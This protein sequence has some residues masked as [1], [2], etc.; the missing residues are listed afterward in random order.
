M[1]YFLSD[2]HLGLDLPHDSSTEREKRIVAFLTECLDDA[3]ELYLLGDIF[4]YW[5]EFRNGEHPN[6]PTFFSVLKK[7]Q[8]KHIPVYQFCGNHDLWLGSFLTDNFDVQIIKQP[9]EKTILGKR[10]YLAHGDG[11]GKGDI[12]YKLLKKLFTSK[13][14]MSLYSILPSRL[15]FSIMKFFSDLSRKTHGHDSFDGRSDRLLA[16]CNEYSTQHDIDYYLMGHRHVLLRLP[17]HD[18]EYIN[19][20]DWLTYDSYASFDGTTLKLVSNTNKT[21]VTSERL[22]R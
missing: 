21:I 5:F 15:G 9:I 20:G 12:G 22:N 2:V 14:S 17:V 4:D 11:V 7:Y 13:V 3:T 1:V 16:F 8:D 18:S 19:L 10:F 6:Y